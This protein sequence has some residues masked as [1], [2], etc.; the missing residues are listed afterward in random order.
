MHVLIIYG[1][2]EG[3]TRKIAEH[4]EALVS[5]LGHE[6]TVTNAEDTTEL[7]LDGV[8]AVILAASV[9]QRRH[10]RHFEA[11]VQ[12]AGAQLAERPT[13]MLSVSLSAAFPEGLEEAGEYLT[14]MKMRTGFEPD[15]EL[16]VGGAIRTDHYDYFSMQVVRFVVLRGKPFDAT[17]GTHEFTDWEAVDA[18]VT[19]FLAARG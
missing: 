11:L 6:V 18:R 14:E 19:E 9:H 17:Q 16:L 4:V 15:G 13:L 1:T 7:G 12:G 10:P 3:Q 2:I 8:D 5:G